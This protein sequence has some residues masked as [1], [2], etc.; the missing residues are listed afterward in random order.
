MGIRATMICAL[1]KLFSKFTFFQLRLHLTSSIIF[2]NHNKINLY[3]FNRVYT[4]KEMEPNEAPTMKSTQ[5]SKITSNLSSLT[6]PQWWQSGPEVPG[7]RL[8]TSKLNLAS[9]NHESECT[10]IKGRVRGTKPF[11]VM[12]ADGRV[13][14]FSYD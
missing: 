9:T 3:L 14:Y 6:N 8:S 7:S 11:T 1:W 12:S 10:S 4:T 13:L 5:A 2:V